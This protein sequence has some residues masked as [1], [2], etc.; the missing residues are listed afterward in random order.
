ML[1]GMEYNKNAGDL[2]RFARMIG[3]APD[4]QRPT[5]WAKIREIRAALPY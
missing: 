4:E 3:K 2:R 1:D 5:L